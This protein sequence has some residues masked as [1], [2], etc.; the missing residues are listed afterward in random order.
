MDYYKA[1]QELLHADGQRVTF[2]L[3][4]HHLEGQVY[5]RQGS[6]YLLHNGGQD[7]CGYEPP[8]SN[9]RGYLRSWRLD[10]RVTNIQ[11]QGDSEM[12]KTYTVQVNLRNGDPAVANTEAENE[13]VASAEIAKHTFEKPCD[14]DVLRTRITFTPVEDG[15]FTISLEALKRL[16]ELAQAS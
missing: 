7:T 8:D 9:L 1:Q 12:A 15:A 16:T 11:L 13:V 5:V 6:I 4:G 10:D 3:K 2:V 14:G